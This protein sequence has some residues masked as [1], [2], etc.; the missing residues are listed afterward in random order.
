MASRRLATIVDRIT[1]C[2]LSFQ[3]CLAFTCEE[4]QRLID[5]LLKANKAKLYY[6]DECATY[7]H[8]IYPRRIAYR[9]RK[10]ESQNYMLQ[11][12]N[13][14]LRHYLA[15]LARRSSRFSRSAEA[16]R[17]DVRLFQFAYNQ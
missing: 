7:Q 8:L 17:C 3:V 5:A 12:I 13:A 4:G 1:H 6:S 14:D 16:L 2:I 15:R 10:G 9:V 11:G